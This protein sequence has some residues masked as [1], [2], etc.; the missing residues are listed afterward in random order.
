MKFEDFL[1]MKKSILFGVLF[2][3]ASV[4]NAQTVYDNELAL[5]YYMPQ[6][7]LC[8]DVEYE[9]EILHKGIFADYAQQYLGTAD[10]IQADA[11]L[12]HIIS[13]RPHTK[14]VADYTRAYKVVA[15]NGIESQLLN[16]TPFGT[17]A[18]YNLPTQA[19]KHMPEARKC[20]PKKP[21]LEG[22]KVMP[23][24]EEHLNGKSIAQQAQGAAKLIYRIRENRMY[25]I[26]GEVDHVP[27][28]GQAMKLVLDEL[29]KQEKQLVDL[30][31][32]TREVIKHHKVL[33]YTP[34]KTEEVEIAYFS[35]TEGFTTSGNGEPI[36]LNITARRQTKGNSRV[37]ADKKA[38]SP[39]QIFYNLPGS[40]IYKVLYLDEILV[41]KQAEIAQFGVAIPLA[42][43]LFTRGELPHIHFDIK[44]GGIKSI[45]K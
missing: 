31:L 21:A 33:S 35:E 20:A 40:A 10:I 24:F 19:P 32:G 36:V 28:D 18:G 30:F 38:P 17:L 27:A 16:L 44:T 14:A 41:E 2:A 12:Y 3:I 4:L 34:A 45:E 11:H 5:I 23:L 7:Q 25:L 29:D 13:V 39:S 22:P 15:E 9:E 6:T 1:Y 42:R 8:F 37:E 26:S 43:T